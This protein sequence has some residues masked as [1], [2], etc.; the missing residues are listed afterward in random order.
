VHKSCSPAFPASQFLGSGF[1]P[2][3]WEAGKAGEQDLCNK[4][5]WMEL[6]NILAAMFCCMVQDPAA[7]YIVGSHRLER[8][9][10]EFHEV[11][12]G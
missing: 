2:R 6:L 9:L 12:D 4:A 10:I 11:S 3:N 7:R 1:I 5:M 8:S